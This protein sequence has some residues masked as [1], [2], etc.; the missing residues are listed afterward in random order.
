MR[1]IDFYFALAGAL[2]LVVGMVMFLRLTR[3]FSA[4]AA[5]AAPVKAAPVVDPAAV[6]STDQARADLNLLPKEFKI[7]AYVQ[8]AADLQTLPRGEAISLLKNFAVAKDSA[9]TKFLCLLLFDLKDVPN[10]GSPF[11]G[12]ALRVTLDGVP[13]IVLRPN[14]QDTRKLPDGR[15]FLNLCLTKGKWS[16]HRYSPVTAAQMQQALDKL[17]D[18][19]FFEVPLT[20]ENKDFLYKQADLAPA[21]K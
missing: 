1:K 18:F 6:K 20:D 10:A 13:F 14:S 15:T 9:K 4:P 2:I 11:A 8:A 12:Q 5:P 17:V 21:A 3:D 16:D 19:P 7:A